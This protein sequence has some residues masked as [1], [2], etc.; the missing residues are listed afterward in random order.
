MVALLLQLWG[1]PFIVHPPY[2][3]PPNPTSSLNLFKTLARQE[4]LLLVLGVTGNFVLDYVPKEIC[5]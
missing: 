1:T 2:I 5:S 3:K 4:I